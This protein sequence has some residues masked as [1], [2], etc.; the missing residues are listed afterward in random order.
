MA[1]CEGDERVFLV[2]VVGDFL[3]VA[4]KEDVDR[5]PVVGRQGDPAQKEAVVQIQR[6]LIRQ[7]HV[8]LIRMHVSCL[9]IDVLN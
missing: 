1:D 2:V 3:E 4:E 5:V 7:V 8:V 6:P 9:V